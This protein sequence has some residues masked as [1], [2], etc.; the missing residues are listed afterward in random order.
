MAPGPAFFVRNL[1]RGYT[2]SAVKMNTG[3]S[4]SSFTRNVFFYHNT[5]VKNQ[6]TG[7][8]L[9]LWYGGST[10]VSVKDIYFKNNIFVAPNGAKCTNIN[11]SNYGGKPGTILNYN[12]WY[13]PTTATNLYQWWD[14]IAIRNEANLSGFRTVSGQEANGMFANPSLNSSHRLNSTSPAID[15]GLRIPGINN[16]YNGAAPDIGA[17]E[18]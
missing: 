8:L 11:T 18:Y 16:Q 7:A 5:F 6:N 3:G 14:G 10:A 15:R 12:L 1:V 9:Y 4:P 2:G 13:T 17:F